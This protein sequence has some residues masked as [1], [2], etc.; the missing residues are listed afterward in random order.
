MR[1]VLALV[2]SASLVLTAC[3]VLGANEERTYRATFTRAIQVFPGG[4]VR[5][6]GVDV[7]VVK[8]VT[9][10]AGGVQVTMVLEDPEIQLPADVEA[11]IVPASLL[12]E[13]YIQLF[14]AYRGGPTLP[15]GGTIPLERTAVP[16]EPDEL[17]RSLQDYLGA[18]DPQ[19]VE[20]FV[21]NAAEILEGN[22]Q[23]LNELIHHAAG[24]IGTL[25]AK[26]D[27]LATIIVEFE[28]LTNALLSRK[29][30]VVRVIKAYNEVVGTLTDNRAALEGSI[31]GLNEMA[32]ELA[33]LLT[34]HRGALDSDID[35][36]T[37]S[38]RTLRRN[39]HTFAATGHWASR[40]FHAAERAIDFDH[41]WLRLNN[42]F[43]ELPGLI[44]QRLKERLVEIC[45]DM[46]LNVCDS[47]SYWSASAPGLF[48]FT[49][50][51]PTEDKHANQP[52]EEQLTEAIE[53]VP[54]LAD[55]LLEQFQQISCAG[56]EDVQQC[57][58]R[59]QILIHC[60]NSAHPRRCLRKNAVL[61]DCLQSGDVQ[62][63]IE[64]QGGGGVQDIVD[65]LLEDTVGNPGNL[66]P[67]GVA[68]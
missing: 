16:S 31:V 25:S 61:I 12:G 21:E 50:K 66:L 49:A 4:K 48:C 58:R 42:Q 60:A 14:P 28:R 2:L 13:R 8:D 26:R 32:V 40:L 17:L 36:L 59:K 38:G 33:S 51:C 19:A 55:S 45:Q 39:V 46:G 35:T 23:E 7:G 68:P 9:N 29:A 34:A 15:P 11:A 44:L 22:G 3:G 67:G 57:L 10:T 6:L 54:A 53:D 65:G 37:T 41:D 18:I 52:P 63:C 1:R 24:V 64:E 47:P 30:E 62:A 27:D 5:V 43:G 20:A 56:A